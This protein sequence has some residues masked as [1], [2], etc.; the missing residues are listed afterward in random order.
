MREINVSISITPQNIS[1]HFGVSCRPPNIFIIAIKYPAIIASQ[2][3]VYILFEFFSEIGFCVSILA[4]LF[5]V[6][7]DYFGL[8]K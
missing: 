5:L 7:E 6:L 8:R 4:F 3:S 2:R 1:S